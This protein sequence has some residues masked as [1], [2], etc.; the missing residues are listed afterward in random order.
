MSATTSRKAVE[1]SCRDPRTI[2]ELLDALR[3][4]RARIPASARELTVEAAEKP[5]ADGE[6]EAFPP[7][8]APA[9]AAPPAETASG[10]RGR[11]M[12]A[13]HS[14]SLSDST[15]SLRRFGGAAA[16]SWR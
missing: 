5:K 7:K 6:P 15:A 3:E 14:G 12:C 10:T 8:A 16:R 4:L 1:A 13:D 11:T 2:E 9:T